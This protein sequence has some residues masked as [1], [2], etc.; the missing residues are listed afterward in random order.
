MEEKEV[1]KRRGV[2]NP[3]DNKKAKEIMKQIKRI[4]ELR[5]AK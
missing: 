5:R 4:K 3:K 1:K 2:S